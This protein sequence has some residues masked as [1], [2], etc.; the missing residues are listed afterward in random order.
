MKQHDARARYLGERLLLRGESLTTAESCTGGLISAVLTE[1]AGASAWFGFGYITYSNL[2]KQQLLGVSAETLSSVG[3]VSERTVREMAEGARSRAAADWS[4]AVSGV[5]GPAGG[6]AEKPVGTVWL[7]IAGPDGQTE[8]WL[9][10]FSGNRA[11]IRRQTVDAAL[12]RL[13][14]LLDGTTLVA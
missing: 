12:E 8:A 11:S 2:A 1:V 9:R 4:I 14:R 3:A 13:C 10:H 7:A 6:S 5:A